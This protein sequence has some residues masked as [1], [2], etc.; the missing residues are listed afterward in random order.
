LSDDDDSRA[1]ERVGSVLNDKWTLE[2]LLGIGGM[3]AVY[4][5]RHRN[6][7]RAAVK[8]MHPELSRHREVCERFRRE[9]YA[10]NRVDHPNVVK[11]LDDDVVASG[12]DSGIA[13]LVME[14][15]EGES[16]QDRLERG[17]PVG[18]R[19]FLTIAAEVLDVLETAHAR[20]V[21][22]R[23][24]KPENL[25][26]LRT[27]SDP[28]ADKPRVK[29]LD[30]GL[31]RLLDGQAITTYGLALG[32]PSFMSPEQ[33]AGRLDE[34][35][36]RTDLFALA[37]TGFRL[38]TGRRIHEGAN[39]VELVR[40]MAAMAAPRV[41]TFAPDASAPFARVID[42]AL[43]FRREDRYEGAGAMRDDVRRAIAELD[44]NARTQ[45]AV[46]V[47]APLLPPAAPSPPEPTMEVSATELESSE[48]MKATRRLGATPAPS[49]ES[50]R[51]PKRRSFLPAVAVAIFLVAGVGGWMWLGAHRRAAHVAAP[52]SPTSS[53]PVAETVTRD[54][55]VDLQQAPAVATAVAS[56]TAHA[57]AAPPPAVPPGD[58]DGSRLRGAGARGP[59]ERATRARPARAAFA[60]ALAR[61]GDSP[62][63][64]EGWSRERPQAQGRSSRA[65]RGDGAERGAS[66]GIVVVLLR[67]RRGGRAR[68][69]GSRW[70]GR[71]PLGRR[72]P[73]YRRA[74]AAG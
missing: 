23:D 69:S 41:Q 32:T 55:G 9:G 28:G 70:S 29:V 50:V 57:S 47:S 52:T 46:S 19:E 44:G 17:T 71:R 26:L 22:H 2:R 34:I 7:A 11:V 18:E 6:G 27:E 49:D 24:L 8:M 53:A 68:R 73:R 12:P 1:H 36:G 61:G 20:G 74:A 64:R 30:F 65:S 63:A 62:A 59:S 25:F 39:A 42:R 21:V 15:L 37:A 16:L 51:L 43:E 48:S 14:L 33:A 60:R 5:A 58:R 13:Y 3:A 56:A 54:S 72:A 10:A 66:V 40:K 67:R 38:R 45:L 31:A 35:D 4:A